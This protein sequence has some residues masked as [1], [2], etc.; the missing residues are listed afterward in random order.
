M[1]YGSSDQKSAQHAKGNSSPGLA[2]QESAQ[3]IKYI[4]KTTVGIKTRISAKFVEQRS[5]VRSSNLTLKNFD[6][7]S[8]IIA[9]IK[10]R[11]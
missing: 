10:M 9:A 8:I 5:Q 11:S 1:N 2:F 3:D 7:S 4:A 6:A